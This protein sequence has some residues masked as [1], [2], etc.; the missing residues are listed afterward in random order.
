MFVT[1]VCF[2]FLLKLLFDCIVDLSSLQVGL[3]VSALA[4]NFGG[5]NLRNILTFSV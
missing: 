3:D 4:F 2:L 5:E 1:A